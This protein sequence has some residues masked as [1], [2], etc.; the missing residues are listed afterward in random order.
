MLIEPLCELNLCAGRLGSGSE[1]AVSRSLSCS[2]R[3]DVGAD[4][5]GTALGFRVY[6]TSAQALCLLYSLY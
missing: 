1:A 3:R 4:A 5:S 2:M 6:A